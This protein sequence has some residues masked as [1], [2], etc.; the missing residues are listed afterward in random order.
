MKTLSQEYKT[1]FTAEEGQPAEADTPKQIATD[2]TIANAT[3]NEIEAGDT[4]LVNGTTAEPVGNG[5][6]NARVADE[7]AN[8]VA[9]SHWDPTTDMSLSQEWVDVSVPRDP[10][11]TDTGLEATPA[12]PANTQ[13]WADEQPDPV[14]EVCLHDAIRQASS[15]QTKQ[16]TPAADPNDG[17]HQVQRNRP[18]HE[19]E[20]SNFRG[21]GNRG[22]YRGRGR[23]EG[24]GRG[25]GG[26]GRG[27][28]SAPSRG[29]RRTEES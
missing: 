14:P 7:A 16:S 10:A 6:A 19:R 1:P 23:G 18:R 3:V 9:E 4:A 21:R 5:I 22:E 13:S 12:A 17:F 27:D 2:P 8:A 26:R 24:R 28:G 15:S 11:E 29:P 20:G 25:R